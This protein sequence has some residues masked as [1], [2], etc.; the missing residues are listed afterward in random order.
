MHQAFAWVVP[1]GPVDL[2][3]PWLAPERPAAEGRLVVVARQ[4]GPALARWV[5]EGEV[6]HLVLLTGRDGFHPARYVAAVVSGAVPGL[7]VAVREVPTTALAALVHA[8]DALGVDAAPAEQLAA[9]D[10]SIGDACTGMWLK[11]VTR[12]RDPNP[13]FGQH[14]RSLFPLKR[15]FVAQLSPEPSVLKKG[16]SPAGVEAGARALLVA[17]AEDSAVSEYLTGMFPDVPVQRVAPITPMSAA[18]GS[19]GAEFLLDAPTLPSAAAP[20]GA[21]PVCSQAMHAASC[22]YCH[23]L[24]PSELA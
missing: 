8:A 13:T 7:A 10:R 20:L 5:A 11:S 3:A 15:G 2:C 23:V 9:F 12:L 18:Y 24:S 16:Q 4:A 21:C 22:S 6:D 14:L 17:C 19:K 1:D